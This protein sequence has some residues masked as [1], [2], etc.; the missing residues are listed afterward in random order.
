MNASG[1]ERSRML[2]SPVMLACL[3][4]GAPL[5]VW[6]GTHESADVGPAPADAPARDRQLGH[7]VR[8]GG[9]VRVG[10]GDR[11]KEVV[12]ILGNADIDGVVERNAVVIGGT[13]TI[14]GTVEGHAVAVGGRMIVHPQATVGAGVVGIGAPAEISPQARI[15]GERIEI[16]GFL[17]RCISVVRQWL[18]CCLLRGRLVAPE[19]PFTVAILVSSLFLGMVLSALF[20]D[21]YRQAIHLTATRPGNVLVAGVLAYTL[22]PTFTFMLMMSVIG[23]PFI[24]ALHL[25]AFGVGMIGLFAV[26][27]HVGDQLFRGLAGFH[28]MPVMASG[29]L[30]AILLVLFAMVPMAGIVVLLLAALVG[31]GAGTYALYLT[32]TGPDTRSASRSPQPP[33]PAEP[34]SGGPQ[35]STDSAPFSSGS[36]HASTGSAQPP[37]GSLHPP[38]GGPQPPTGTEGVSPAES[39]PAS[40][41]AEP[42]D[43]SVIPARTATFWERSGAIAVDFILLLLIHRIV[44]S[45]ILGLFR[46]AP[47]RQGAG[48]MVLSLLLVYLAIMWAWKSTTVG[49]TIFNLKVQRTDGSP[50][51]LS[52]AVVRALAV[53]LSIAPLGLGFFWMVWDENRQT[54]HDRIAGT[55]VVRLPAGV[56]LLD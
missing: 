29:V 48:S 41:H 42:Q 13:L 23:I 47:V 43:K 24:P 35:P 50:L 39:P 1:H 14:S 2:W 10:S 40:S 3:L 51:N 21:L 31:M 56:N 32:A 54:W 36:T 18:E 25:I 55:R 17:Q 4:L 12:V 8:I 11:G 15:S 44:L 38:I 6:S 52:V 22:V 26:L 46:L 16:G 9:D 34:P 30:V 5:Y 49:N 27:S 37:T 19:M 20:S 53:I 45:P 7:L 33:S 28:R